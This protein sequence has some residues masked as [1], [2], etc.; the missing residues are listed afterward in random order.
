MGY[1]KKN[2]NM[3]ISIWGIKL[4]NLLVK[5]VIAVQ[6]TISTYNL[7]EVVVY[8]FLLVIDGR[9]TL[10]TY[11]KIKINIVPYVL[12]LVVI[13]FVYMSLPYSCS[14]DYSCVPLLHRVGQINQFGFDK[15]CIL[16]KL[17]CFTK[18]TSQM[19]ISYPPNLVHIL[20]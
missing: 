16:C 17:A 13:F 14:T 10:S 3:K 20:N 19:G 11:N 7:D 9:H 12:L 2:S 1:G 4:I 18:P 15:T 6:H 5:L 8:L